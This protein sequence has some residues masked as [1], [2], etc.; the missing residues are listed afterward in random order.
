M[1]ITNA[2]H[3]VASFNTPVEYREHGI[4]ESAMH[5]HQIA[6]YGFLYDVALP[7][8]GESGDAL[9]SQYLSDVEPRMLL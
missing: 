7:R 1:R 9:N 3:L 8:A 4:N 2:Q 5:M 6:K